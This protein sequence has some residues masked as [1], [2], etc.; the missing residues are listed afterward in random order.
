MKACGSASSGAGI[1]SPP[2]SQAIAD[3]EAA[4]AKGT[5]MHL[6]LAGDYSAPRAIYHPLPLF[7]KSRASPILSAACLRKSHR[8]RDGSRLLIRSGVNSGFP[9][10]SCGN[11]EFEK[12]ILR[13]LAGLYRSIWIGLKE[14]SRRERTRGRI[15]VCYRVSPEDLSEELLT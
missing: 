11:A 7:T 12:S 14:V 10:F 6:R 15:A 9:I 8:G 2:P 5:R 1:A 13:N 4:T 3:S